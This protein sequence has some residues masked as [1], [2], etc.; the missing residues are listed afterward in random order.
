M[1]L[2]PLTLNNHEDHSDNLLFLDDIFETVIN[3]RTAII[4]G[5]LLLVIMTL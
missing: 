5:L 1:L 4:A 3:A 2:A